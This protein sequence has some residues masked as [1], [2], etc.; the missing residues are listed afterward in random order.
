MP[1]TVETLAVDLMM[2]DS[3]PTQHASFAIMS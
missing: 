3:I 1:V 2:P